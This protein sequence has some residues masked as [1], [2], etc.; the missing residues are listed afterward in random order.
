MKSLGVDL[1]GGVLNLLVNFGWILWP[2]VDVSQSIFLM[3][4]PQ[5]WPRD[6]P[7]AFQ[8]RPQPW[9]CLP[10]FSALT[11]S[12]LKL[13]QT[14][15]LCSY[16]SGFRALS[17]RCCGIEKQWDCRGRL[18]WWLCWWLKMAQG[19]RVKTFSVTLSGEVVGRNIDWCMWG[20]QIDD[21]QGFPHG[22]KSSKN[23][24]N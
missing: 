5:C 20:A 14:E 11:E 8:V 16:W 12:G 7:R 19:R 13:V 17:L 3:R 1:P 23:Q 4:A 10:R 6:K 18:C 21:L 22:K 15:N 9:L 24:R 2:M